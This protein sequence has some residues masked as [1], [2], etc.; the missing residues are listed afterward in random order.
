[1]RAAR[2]HPLGND[3]HRLAPGKSALPPG[4]HFGLHGGAASDLP[5]LLGRHQRHRDLVAA[6][7]VLHDPVLLQG[8]AVFAHDC[9]EDGLQHRGWIGGP[10]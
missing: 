1:M 10:M 5:C 2:A 8:K 9:F 7:Q 4:V 6:I 3:L